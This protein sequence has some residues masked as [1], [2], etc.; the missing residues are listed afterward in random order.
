MWLLTWKFYVITIYTNKH[1]CIFIIQQP[2]HTVTSL[3]QLEK[4][5]Q[6][7]FFGH[8]MSSKPHLHKTQLQHHW[9]KIGGVWYVTNSM[10]KIHHTSSSKKLFYH[11]IRVCYLY[12][13]LV[14]Y[15]KFDSSKTIYEWIPFEIIFLNVSKTVKCSGSTAD[16]YWNDIRYD[17][18]MRSIEK[19]Y[20]KFMDCHHESITIGSININKRFIFWQIII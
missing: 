14:F 10:Q 4:K 16:F 8:G 15:C 19:F 5:S 13:G 12:Q 7:L 3:T 18:D 1:I 11:S 2:N 6:K 9:E 17:T 20:I